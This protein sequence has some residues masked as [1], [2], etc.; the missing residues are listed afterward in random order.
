MSFGQKT[1][2]I[3]N[4]FSTN[5]RRVRYVNCFPYLYPSLNLF[6]SI[7]FCVLTQSAKEGEDQVAS[8]RAGAGESVR[9]VGEA[10]DLAVKTVE[11]AGHAGNALRAVAGGVGALGEL[12]KEFN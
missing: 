9:E 8:R 5:F 1:K 12:G 3:H 4:K 6:I 2:N 10:L 7:T 11:L